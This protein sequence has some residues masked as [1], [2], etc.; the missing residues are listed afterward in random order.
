MKIFLLRIW[1]VWRRFRRDG[2]QHDARQLQSVS[3][4]ATLMRRANPFASWNERARW[5]IDTVEWVR[6]EPQAIM[7]EQDAAHPA[8]RQRVHL[9]LEWLDAHRE[10]RRVVRTTLQKTLREAVGPEVFSTTGLPHEP[11]FFSELVER[12]FKRLL[13]GPPVQSDLST[14]FAALFPKPADADWLLGLDQETMERLWRLCADDA[15]A[16]ACHRQID[17]ALLYLS[18]T[19]LAV[20]ISPAFRQRLEPRMP[21]QATPFMALQREL[22]KYLAAGYSDAAALRSVRMLIAVCQAQTDRI[23]AHLDEFGVSIGLVYRIER[24]RAQLSRMVRLIDLREALHAGQSVDRVRDLVRDLAVSCHHRSSVRGLI[25]NS[26]SLSAR[27][28]V[29]RNA[30]RGE[31]LIARDGAGYRTLLAAACIGGIIAALTMLGKLA[32]TGAGLARFFEGAFI[33]MNYAI[34]FIAISAMGGVLAAK[35][36][37]VTAP[38]LASK[39]GA[40]YTADGLR[41]LLA[42]AAILLRS[43]AAAVLGNLVAVVP[44]MV[45][46]SLAIFMLAGAPVMSPQK[47]HASLNGLSIA[48]LTPVFAAVTGVLLWMAGMAAGMADNWFALRQLRAALTH[49]RRLAFALGTARAERL[50]RWL[51]RHIA[52]IAGN[53]SLAVLLGMTPVIAEFF[54]LPFDIRHATLAAATLAA[55]TA[56]LDWQVFALPAFWL[57]LGGVMI[58]PLLNIGVAFA[59]ALSLALM[60]RD[61]PARIRKIVFRTMAR[62]MATSPRWFLLPAR[63]ETEVMTMSVPDEEA[64]TEEK[65]RKQAGG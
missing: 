33:S 60:A 54:G 45:A 7:P 31:G 38:A 35:Q 14:L 61:V 46:L 25:R 4:I 51:E 26:F 37:A 42:E 57:A 9:L 49:H 27:R 50:A 47:A 53:L 3:H 17:E 48:G 40:L 23:Y 28:M 11:A 62:A 52:S 30:D 65:R 18:T 44:T 21:L 19:I 1:A 13:P 43:Q 55:A 34:G 64:A 32:L 6:C 15:I 12:I 22:E 58:V 63:P 59:C 29:E 8:P 20:G 16:H 24:M 36:P 10:V 41:A 5:M 39:M 2:A 56:S